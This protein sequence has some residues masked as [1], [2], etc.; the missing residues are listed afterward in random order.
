MTFPDGFEEG[1]L[2]VIFYDG[3]DNVII[4]P[5]DFYDDGGCADGHP[6]RR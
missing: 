1:R 6:Q 3:A 2:V 5:A 4:K